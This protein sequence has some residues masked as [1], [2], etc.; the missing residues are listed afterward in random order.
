[1]QFFAI[2]ASLVHLFKNTVLYCKRPST[3]TCS[4]YT[5]CSSSNMLHWLLLVFVCCGYY[6]AWHMLLFGS[7]SCDHKNSLWPMYLLLP[8]LP[9][10]ESFSPSFCIFSF[11]ILVVF[12]GVLLYV[13]SPIFH[14]MRGI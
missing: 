14:K 2:L 13:P 3:Y 7:W 5:C 1:M 12:C 8:L 4:V 6:P 10:M 9:L 11:V